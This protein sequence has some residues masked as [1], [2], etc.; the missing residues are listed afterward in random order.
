M[1]GS[2]PN[3]L[4]TV[5]SLAE[6]LAEK[7]HR[8]GQS[9]EAPAQQDL[10]DRVRRHTELAL[11]DLGCPRPLAPGAPSPELVGAIQ[12]HDLSEYDAQLV[13][14]L[15]RLLEAQSGLHFDDRGALGVR[16]TGE[17][18]GAAPATNPTGSMRL[19]VQL[20]DQ[21]AF[22]PANEPAVDA[23]DFSG[24]TDAVSVPELI[25]FFQLQA[26]TG[27]LRIEAE[28]ETFSLT[29]IG[30]ELCRVT[31]SRSPAGQR[32]GDLL[33]SLGY[34]TEAR[35]QE[36]LV[37][38]P[39]GMKIGE[40]L[41]TTGGLLPESISAALKLQVQGIFERL[42]NVTGAN[43]SFHADTGTDTATRRRYNVTHLLL[44]TARRKDEDLHGQRQ[45]LDLLE[46]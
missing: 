8:L 41:R 16:S 11:E 44:E 38:A 12:A 35:L 37:D 2:Y 26:K 28:Q 27:V 32:L 18:R 1:S 13:G 22:E 42:C 19:R 39:S 21:A 30:G 7:L 17:S 6:E 25:G 3:T 15:G 4:T 10:L 24:H 34:I 45:G 14:A 46:G 9:P 5:R 36:L 40:V 31:S 33:V 23:P 43:F 20:D 29:Y